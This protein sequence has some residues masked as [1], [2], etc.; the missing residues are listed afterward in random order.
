MFSVSDVTETFLA[1][2]QH[3]RTFIGPGIDNSPVKLPIPTKPIGNIVFH[4]PTTHIAELPAPDDSVTEPES[5]V[6][7]GDPGVAYK[8]QSAVHSGCVL[9][10]KTTHVEPAPCANQVPA[11]L[12]LPVF[13]FPDPPP[14][15]HC[16]V[17]QEMLDHGTLTAEDIAIQI[18]GQAL[19]NALDHYDEYSDITVAGAQPLNAYRAYL[20][21]KDLEQCTMER[22]LDKALE[23]VQ[24]MDPDAED[25]DFDMGDPDVDFNE[26]MMHEGT[27]ADV[28]PPGLDDED[29]P[30]PFK[31][32]EEFFMSN[33]SHA[34]S[35]LPPHLLTIYAVTT[36][37]HLQ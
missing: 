15:S 26:D 36:W 6:E 23:E 24:Q 12:L 2:P 28:I 9:P 30:D 20:L 18:H 35:T 7:Q 10:H 27:S 37:L 31:L 3:L 11:P 29:S 14:V 16:T 19:L 22:E 21:P 8:L 17:E 13:D 25:M 4:P 32:D 34:M 33:G 5:E 1:H